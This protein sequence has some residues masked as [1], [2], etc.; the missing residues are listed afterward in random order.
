[1]IHYVNGKKN[2]NCALFPSS[3]LKLFIFI[4]LV[5][6][7]FLFSQVIVCRHI[8]CLF[9]LCLSPQ[10]TSAM[11]S[12]MQFY[13]CISVNDCQFNLKALHEIYDRKSLDYFK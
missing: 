10:R 13:V 6:K 2:R 11:H 9:Y 12:W 5:F 7:L 1:M 8:Y 4:Q 3:V